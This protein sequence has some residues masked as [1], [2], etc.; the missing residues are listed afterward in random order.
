MALCLRARWSF[1][2]FSSAVLLFC[3]CE[4][5]IIIFMWRKL[6]K[7][8]LKCVIKDFSF[9]ASAGWGQ[10]SAGP[11]SYPSLWLDETQWLNPPVLHMDRSRGLSSRSCSLPQQTNFPENSYRKSL[12][13]KPVLR[14]FFF[15]FFPFLW[16]Q[17]LDMS[18][19]ELLSLES[20]GDSGGDSN[21]RRAVCRGL[22]CILHSI[23][24]TSPSSRSQAHPIHLPPPR[25]KDIQSL[26]ISHHRDQMQG[27][28]LYLNWFWLG[29]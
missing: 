5:R 16:M 27:K 9:I 4:I 15:L 8:K 1:I 19:R 6:G 26:H 10:F 2:I 22:S 14:F 7:S 29:L 13:L 18:Q 28:G 3:N 21:S 23:I 17:R 25:G 24:S 11:L 20:G 12:E